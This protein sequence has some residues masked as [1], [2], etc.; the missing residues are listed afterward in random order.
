MNQF[1]IVTLTEQLIGLP[2]YKLNTQMSS[3]QKHLNVPPDFIRRRILCIIC[4]PNK[5]VPFNVFDSFLRAKS[6]N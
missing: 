1:L 5:I 2:M 4:Q 3:F 6:F